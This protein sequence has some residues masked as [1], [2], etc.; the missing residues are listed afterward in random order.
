MI[1]IKY[2]SNCIHV[3]IVVSVPIV[4]EGCNNNLSANEIDLI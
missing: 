2:L 4:I 3:G 1:S